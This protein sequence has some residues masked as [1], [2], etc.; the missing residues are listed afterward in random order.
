MAKPQQFGKNTND[1]E[2]LMIWAL[3]DV[4]DKLKD[5][6]GKKVKEKYA[7]RLIESLASYNIASFKMLS[8]KE[9]P[10]LVTNSALKTLMNVGLINESAIYATK[11]N[12]QNEVGGGYVDSARYVVD[13]IELRKEYNANGLDV[14]LVLDGIVPIVGS[15]EEINVIKCK[16]LDDPY[17]VLEKI[18]SQFYQ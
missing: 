15:K 14:L 2:E 9:E 3:K 4:L 16:H 18:V 5:V 1:G 10:I 6:L 13:P 12:Y 17:P 11:D 8:S 7:S